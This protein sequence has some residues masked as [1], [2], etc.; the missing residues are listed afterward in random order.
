MNNDYENSQ[1]AV[2]EVAALSNVLNYLKLRFHEDLIYGV[3]DGMRF[4]LR[5]DI[6]SKI[7]YPVPTIYGNELIDA[8]LE[9]TKLKSTQ[10]EFPKTK[11][12]IKEILLN[13]LKGNS[14]L[15]TKTLDVDSEDNKLEHYFTV[16]PDEDGNGYL[17]GINSNTSLEVVSLDEI[18]DLIGANKRN[19]ISHY[20][21]KH[22]NIKKIEIKNIVR[23]IL[24][25]TA[26][27]FL[28]AEEEGLSA[29]MILA[30][31]IPK[32]FKDMEKFRAFAYKFNEL[33]AKD[34]TK[35][36]GYRTLF[37]LYLNVLIKKVDDA[38]GE[39]KCA[40]EIYKEIKERWIVFNAKLQE[41]AAMDEITEE[42]KEEIMH[43]YNF[44]TDESE[45]LAM[46]FLTE[47]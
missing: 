41:A 5:K 11:S 45:R 21:E 22:N 32:Y 1:M 27:R 30:K 35:G 9:N 19:I 33:W 26:T 7:E 17:L 13:E 25:T 47:L 28:E 24:K 15:L 18:V 6:K 4:S 8:F 46:T 38:T 42:L 10:I 39:I 40:H 37:Y 12:K 16:S 20:F 44:N 34:G 3:A 31:K 14:I 36:S 43:R 29:M 23:A 2:S